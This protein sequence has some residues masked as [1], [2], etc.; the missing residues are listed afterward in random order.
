MK[1]KAILFGVA[2][3]GF[4]LFGCTPRNQN[5]SDLIHINVS[6][7]YPV[8]EIRLAEIADIEFVQ[9]EMHDD[10][11]FMGAPQVITSDKIILGQFNGDIFVFSRT[12]KPLSRFNRRGGGPEEFPDFRWL[13]YDEATDEIFVQSSTGIMVYSSTGEFQ[14]VIPLLE[15]SSVGDLVSF[16]SEL[17]LLY[18]RNDVYPAPFVLI[19]KKDGEIIREIDTPRDEMIHPFL[20]LQD[21]VSISII[22][23]PAHHIVKHND[24]FLLTD[25]A[26][27]TVYFLSQN[28]ELSPILTRSPAIQSMNTI[29][30]L[31]SFIEAGG[32]QFF[33]AVTVRNENGRLPR[34]YLM[35]DKRTD[36]I[37][38][39]RITFDEF[40]GREITLSPT[41]ITNTQNSRLGLISLDLTELQDAND[42]GRLSG[43]LKELVENSEEDGNNVFMLLHFK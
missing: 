6:R 40:R 27:D 41:T 20:V 17:L 5:D 18:D 10:F 24:G 30:Y 29:I 33:S 13:V 34:T 28:R 42:E 8:K 14:R 21:E 32:Y 23:A 38:R 19:S 9:L 31:N 11:L 2:L 37:Y 36:A 43:R 26:L 22:A 39:Q 3:S 1:F 12:G 7:S 15:R 16:D 35:R 25:F 4:F